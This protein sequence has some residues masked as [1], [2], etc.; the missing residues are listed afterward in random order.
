MLAYRY[1]STYTYVIIDNLQRLNYNWYRYWRNLNNVI[2]A[3]IDPNNMHFKPATQ[4]I[5]EE[6]KIYIITNVTH[7]RDARVHFAGLSHQYYSKFMS[8]EL[9][10]II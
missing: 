5:K 7:Y 10:I 4:I 8:K 1:H 6:R 9:V 2:I 3:C